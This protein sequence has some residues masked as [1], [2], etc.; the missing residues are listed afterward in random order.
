M[1]VKNKGYS[2]VHFQSDAP[3]SFALHIETVLFT[4]PLLSVQSSFDLLKG[5]CSRLTQALSLFGQMG[6]CFTLPI[7]LPV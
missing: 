6:S 4:L 5:L 7:H 2:L 3:V 1:K